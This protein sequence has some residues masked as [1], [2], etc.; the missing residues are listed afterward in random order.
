MS[1]RAWNVKLVFSFLTADP[2]L[3]L[4]F[5]IQLRDNTAFCKN[6]NN[7]NNNNTYNVCLCPLES[8]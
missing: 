3:S 1:S 2:T 4:D 8:R 5:N 6:N 7:N